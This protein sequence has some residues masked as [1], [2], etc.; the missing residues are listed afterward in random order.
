MSKRIKLPD[1]IYNELYEICDKLNI[2]WIIEY[3]HRK[4]MDV[5]DAKCLLSEILGYAK[6]VGKI[7]MSSELQQWL[8]QI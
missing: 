5:Y 7:E 1:S 3:R 2:E 4:T 8:N 6:H